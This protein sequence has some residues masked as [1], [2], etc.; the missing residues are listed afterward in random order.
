MIEHLQ[1]AKSKLGYKWWRVKRSVRSALSSVNNSP[2]LVLGNQKSGTT[3]IAAL[4]AEKAGLS[5]TLDLNEMTAEDERKMHKRE[6]GLAEFVAS[7]KLEFSRDLIKEPRL[8]FLYPKLRERFPNGQYV[9]IIRDPRDNI[10]SILNR[11][12]L[13][14]DK[15]Y[16][17]EG[18]IDSIDPVWSLV[19]NG[20][21]MGLSGKNYVDMLAARWSRSARTYLDHD[22]AFCL[23]RYEN[24][25][26]DKVGT[27]TGLAE[28]LGLEK[29]HAID[30]KVDVQ[31]QPRGNRSVDWDTF[32]G[33]K[34]L[35]RIENLCEPAMSSLGYST[36]M[37]T[38]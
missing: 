35:Y 28:Q 8:T 1:Q 38:S 32:F 5:A 27:I 23:V 4:L 34:N 30:D 20:E 18:E 9:F 36:T 19:L 17:G 13:P 10:R 2:I 24:F 22:D 6:G 16:L 3:A 11:L 14:G 25:V 15:K 26:A 21:W 12:E 31:Y 37:S 33:A 29:S 7:H